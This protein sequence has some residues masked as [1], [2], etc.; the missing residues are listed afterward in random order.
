MKWL[1]NMESIATTKSSGSCPHCGSSD[2]DYSFIGK[3][4]AVGYGVIWC[5]AC[6][7][8]YRISR[9]HIPAGYKVNNPI[10]RDIVYDN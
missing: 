5:N 7:R 6:K 3:I 2:T 8:A 1:N 9:M 4:S 10:P